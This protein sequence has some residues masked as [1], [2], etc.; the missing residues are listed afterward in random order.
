MKYNIA[1]GERICT[2]LMKNDI[3]EVVECIN[4]NEGDIVGYDTETDHISEILQHAMGNN[5]Y[6]FVTD[7]ELNTINNLL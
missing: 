5:Y 1:F 7:D 3:A 6:A 4:D 2:A